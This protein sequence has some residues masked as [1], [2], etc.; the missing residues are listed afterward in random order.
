MKTIDGISKIKNPVTQTGLRVGAVT[1]TIDLFAKRVVVRLL[2]QIQIGHLT[3][4]EGGET[5]SFGQPQYTAQHVAHINIKSPCFYRKVML[6]GTIGAGESFMDGDWTSP[7]LT[8]LVQLVVLNQAML[9]NMDSKWSAAY[10]GVASLVDRLNRNSKSGSKKNIAAHYDLSNDFFKLFLDE[11]MMY[12]SAI[13]PNPTTELAAAASYKLEHICRR[14]KLQPTDHL[15]EIGSG[16][17]GMAIYAAKH[18]GCRVTTTTISEQQYQYALEKIREEG[19]EEQITLLKKDYRELTGVFDK[20]VS[21]EM[22]EAVGHDYYQQYFTK[23][24]DLLSPSGLM[25]IQAITTTD[26]RFQREKNNID[27]I[28]KYIFPGGCLPSNA[29]I[30]EHIANDTDMHLVCLGDLTLDYAVTLSDWQRRFKENL[31][32]VYEQGFDDRFVRMW[33]FYLSYCEGGFRERVI[34]TSQF[35]FAKPLCRDIPYIA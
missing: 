18:Y 30:A 24:N 32:S 5:S 19:L 7:N 14:L 8:K 26:Q 28:R 17:G 10:K 11:K 31:T 34:N 1:S 25:L 20:L 4:E 29:V 6:A 23:C 2:K 13:Y 27:F 33:E 21:I 15:L 35:V 12:S 3:L 16:W 9:R 22:I